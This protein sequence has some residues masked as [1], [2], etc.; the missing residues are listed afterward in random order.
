M[1]TQIRVVMDGHDTRM[2][3]FHSSMGAA[4]A[5]EAA[6]GTL[7]ETH[8]LSVN[9]RRAKADTPVRPGDTVQRQPMALHG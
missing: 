3:N 8:A 7:T 4:A 1:N 5:I 6:G 9:G 2:V